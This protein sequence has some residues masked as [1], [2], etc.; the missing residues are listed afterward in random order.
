MLERVTLV[1]SDLQIITGISVLLAGYINLFPATTK[2]PLTAYHWQILIYLAW[3]SSNVHLTTLSLLRNWL[4][5]SRV[6]LI[7]RIVGMTVLLLLLLAAL[8]PTVSKSWSDAMSDWQYGTSYGVRAYCFWE[9]AG[10]GPTNLNAPFSFGLLILSYSWKIAQLKDKTRCKLRKY[11]RCAPEWALERLAVRELTANHRTRY[12]VVALMYVS[13]VA[14]CEFIESFSACLWLVSIGLLWGSIQ[15]FMPR[16]A[17]GPHIRS[18]ESVWSFGQMLP[19]LFLIQ[20]A[21]TIIE[22]CYC[23][24]PFGSHLLRS[25]SKLMSMVSGK[26][27]E[28]GDDNSW[29][30]RDQ[31]HTCDDGEK[32]EHAPSARPSNQRNHRRLSDILLS[33]GVRS[34]ETEA[35]NRLL[36]PQ[37][38]FL[39]STRFFRSILWMIQ[40][41]VFAWTTIIVT[42]VILGGK[43]FPTD[44]YA[45]DGDYTLPFLLWGPGNQVVLNVAVAVAYGVGSMAMYVFCGSFLSRAF[46]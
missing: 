37:L 43:L 12:R 42:F 8:V 11:F 32:F 6:L 18:E 4:R 9:V 46:K 39:Y 19:L 33:E 31:S 45:H 27:E 21:A 34:P 3:M 16:G 1:F 17:V 15:I 29:T 2:K 28:G 10:E 40:F 23:K 44:Q 30:G 13:F 35:D 38:A 7:C 24:F 22:L 5:Q 26:P 20:P 25:R 41:E 14:G 36:E